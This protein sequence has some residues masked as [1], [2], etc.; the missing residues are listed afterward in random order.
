MTLSVNIETQV[1]ESQNVVAELEGAG[2]GLVI[3]GGHYDVVPQTEDGA[4]DNTSGIAV[5]LGVGRSTGQ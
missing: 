5:R 4:N 1:L 3:V 2:D